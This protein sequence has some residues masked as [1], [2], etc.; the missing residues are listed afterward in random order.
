MEEL[1][2]AAAKLKNNKLILGILIIGIV[3]LT[4]PYSGGG[5]DEGDQRSDYEMRLTE[6]TEETLSMI[7]GAGKVKVMLTL[8]ND[9][10]TYPVTE[11]SQSGER[12]V[13]SS[14]KLAVS[15][16]EYPVVRGVIVV[17]SGADTPGVSEDITEAVRAVTGAPL[18][19]IRVFKMK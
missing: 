18:C 6:K 16:E 15:K 14:G 5:K 17:A 3:L 11:K 13:S 8:D 10:T 12:T 7:C 1:K 4:V 2:K 19:N 9:G